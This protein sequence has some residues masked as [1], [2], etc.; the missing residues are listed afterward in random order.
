MNIKWQYGTPMPVK[1]VGHTAVWLNG[2]VYV[3]GGSETEYMPSETIDCYDPICD[4]WSSIS[5]PYSYFSVTKLKNNL[6]LAGGMDKNYKKTKDILTLNVSQFK[7]Y[8]KMSIVRTLATAVGYQGILII[9]GG[10]DDND[11]VLSSTELFDSKNEQWY[12]CS[13]LPQPHFELQSVIADNTL[14]LLSG[15]KRSRLSSK[16]VLAASLD[17]LSSHELKWDAF[18]DTPCFWPASMSVHDTHLLLLGGVSTIEYQD[19]CSYDIYKLNKQDSNTSWKLAGHIPVERYSSVAVT[20]VDN[21]IIIMGGSND[22]RE[23]TNT[24]LI[25]SCEP[26]W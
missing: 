18:P 10:K 9:T 22:M 2:Q 1:R 25:G 3:G 15:Y 13:N 12:T 4:S 8:T 11:L 24:V 17:A 6:I 26:Q 16:K 7:I 14:Y 23:M 5:T 19:V 20:T 21:K